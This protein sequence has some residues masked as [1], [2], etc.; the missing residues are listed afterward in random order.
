[1]SQ[2][3]ILILS[4][5][6]HFKHI[7]PKKYTSKVYLLI[8]F[9]LNKVVF[10]HCQLVVLIDP[11]CSQKCL[12]SVVKSNEDL[13]FSHSSLCA[14]SFC[15]PSHSSFFC[16]IWH[17]ANPICVIQGLITKAASGERQIPWWRVA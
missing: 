14:P 11:L 4:T 16:D 3:V 2:L 10:Q 15:L 5:C 6:S 1:M 7:L 17:V 13:I 9:F 8:S 12:Q